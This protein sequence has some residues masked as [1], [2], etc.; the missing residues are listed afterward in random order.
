MRPPLPGKPDKN[1]TEFKFSIPRSNPDGSKTIKKT[2]SAKQLC[3][4]P[5]RVFVPVS[6]GSQV[7]YSEL[8]NAGQQ[9]DET[10]P[11]AQL[12]WEGDLGLASGGSYATHQ[13]QMLSGEDPTNFK[14]KANLPHQQ[15]PISTDSDTAIVSYEF[16]I[17]GHEYTTTSLQTFKWRTLPQTNIVQVI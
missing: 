17:T 2:I 7:R 1:V 8:T 13:P 10:T 9:H 4:R 12:A 5:N 15:R 6:F 14:I 16:P 11:W 3:Q